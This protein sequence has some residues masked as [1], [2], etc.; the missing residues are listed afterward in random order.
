MPSTLPLHN[1]EA[2]KSTNV[3]VMKRLKSKFSIKRASAKK[4]QEL[5]LAS[6]SR[7]E[8][9]A[10]SAEVTSEE[11]GWA[12]SKEAPVV[13]NEVQKEAEPFV[14][15]DMDELIESKAETKAEDPEAEDPEALRK[16]EEAKPI[17]SAPAEAKFE[18]G[19]DESKSTEEEGDD[20]V[21]NDSPAKHSELTTDVMIH[22]GACLEP[23][24]EELRCVPKE[25]ELETPIPE[26]TTTSPVPE[27]GSCEHKPMPD[28]Q[29]ETTNND[30]PEAVQ[31]LESFTSVFGQHI[32]TLLCSDVWGSRQDGFD[33]I[34]L[35]VKKQ[36][37][38]STEEPDVAQ[39]FSASLVAINRGLEDRV[40]PVIYAALECVRT[41]I[42]YL[43]PF[44]LHEDECGLA[45]VDL[46]TQL[47]L[48]SLS[49][50]MKMNDTS[51]RTRK[52]VSRVILRLVRVPQ[53][54]GVFS[55]LF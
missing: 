12:E 26:T 24:N 14:N 27:T 28:I 15:E 44:M 37:L 43:G 13:R 55:S 23:S 34:A 16:Q 3:G 9:T 30:H 4:S 49:L 22:E 20:R 33:A 5:Q 52:E 47:S 8:E 32:T 54:S 40:I 39:L 17:T 1:Q 50:I 31:S 46:S 21:V 6:D 2:K 48:L 36:A 42:K 35:S 7:I 41:C 19:D 11:K 45:D 53:V 10:A 38:E 25:E 51:K 29:Q 18:K